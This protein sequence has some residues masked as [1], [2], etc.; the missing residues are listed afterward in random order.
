MDVIS[1]I[2]EISKSNKARK[3]YYSSI[4]C[5][6]KMEDIYIPVYFCGGSNGEAKYIY[7]EYNEKY[8]YLICYTYD[9]YDD[10]HEYDIYR[11]YFGKDNTVI[12]NGVKNISNSPIKRKIDL[13]EQTYDF[14]D[15]YQDD[16]IDYILVEN[17]LDDSTT[18]MKNE[19][20]VAIEKINDDNFMIDNVITEIPD[21]ITNKF[22]EFVQGN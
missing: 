4:K 5:Y 15:S 7:H 16:F 2:T 14:F 17:I 9:S 21:H 22:V 12:I 13:L 8:Y 10:Y 11:I 19:I 20:K 1:H 18:L 6:H 3:E